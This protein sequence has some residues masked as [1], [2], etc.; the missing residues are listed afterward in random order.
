MKRPSLC[1]A[2]FSIGANPSTRSNIRRLFGNIPRQPKVVLPGEP[3][4]GGEVGGAALSGSEGNTAT[5][6]SEGS[7]ALDLYAGVGLFALPMAR[8]FASVT[9]VEAGSSAVRDLEVNAARAGACGWNTRGWRIISRVSKLR[10]ISCSPTLPAPGSAKKSSQHLNRARA[11]AAHHRLLRSRDAGPRPGGA[12]R[13]LDRA[14]HAGGSVPADV[15]Y[16]D[17]CSPPTPGIRSH[18]RQVETRPPTSGPAL[19]ISHLF[20]LQ[21]LVCFYGV[22]KSSLAYRFR[23]VVRPGPMLPQRSKEGA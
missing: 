17:G 10:R 8:R 18:S 16:R 21:R 6:G 5:T 15:S 1:G 11:A 19:L 9:A 7:T 14:P 4:P 13:L 20:H 12:A 23:I 3:L 22:P 2:T